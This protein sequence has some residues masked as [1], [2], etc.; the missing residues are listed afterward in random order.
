MALT[1]TDLDA[2][3]DFDDPAGS[4]ARIRTALADETSPIAHGELRTQL[5]R[6]LGLAGRFSEAHAVLDALDPDDPHV[7]VRRDLERGR[8][9]NS[10]GDPGEAIAHFRAAAELSADDPGLLFLH[11]D[12]LHM[13]AIADA[14]NAE[15]W[16]ARGIAA[17]EGATDDR[18]RRWLVGLNNN[19]GWA[20]FDLGDLPGAR[21]A[22]EA[23]ADAA[24]RYGT[25][26]QRRFAAE[27]LAEVDAASGDVG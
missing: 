26:S 20:R 14:E 2:L 6:A 4:E 11:V 3:W 21:A 23:A 7:A 10:A 1:Q 5:A 12:A 27:A 8:L 22:F 9:H 17:L 16:T 18:T 24:E 19:L 25:E 15:D 13:L